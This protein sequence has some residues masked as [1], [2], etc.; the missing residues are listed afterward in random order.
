[1]SSATIGDAQ[2]EI[3]LQRAAG[4]KYFDPVSYVF[5]DINSADEFDRHQA[6]FDRWDWPSV[7]DESV[8]DYAARAKREYQATDRAAIAS[9]RMHY[10]QAGQIMRGYEQFMIDLLTDEVRDW[11]HENNIAEKYRITTM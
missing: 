9:W 8:E 10:L 11:L 6:V 2:G 7:L 4:G 3:R 5:A 1:M